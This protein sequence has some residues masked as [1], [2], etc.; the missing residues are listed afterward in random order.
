[1]AG[2]SVRDHPTKGLGRTQT[3]VLHL[4]ASMEHGAS[5]ADIAGSGFGISADAAR[6][7]LDTLGR[8]GLVDVRD[9]RSGDLGRRFALTARGA[10]VEADLLEERRI[11]W[12]LSE[13]HAA[14]IEAALDLY[15]ETFRRAAAGAEMEAEADEWEPDMARALSIEVAN[16]RT[17]ADA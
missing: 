12:K 10:Q 16:L 4:L 11:V 13:Q 17:A 2:H 3:A 8:R 1:M 15:H 7:T 9:R 5:A 6:S 14:V